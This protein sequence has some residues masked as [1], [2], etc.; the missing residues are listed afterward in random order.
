MNL[1]GAIGTIAGFLVVLAG[2][3]ALCLLA[4]W[5]INELP[6]DNKG[7]NILSIVTGTGGVVGT[8]VGAYFGVKLGSAGAKEAT[9][10]AVELAA[11]ADPATAQA[12]LQ[13][14]PSPSH[15]AAS[16]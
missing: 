15:P 7:Q 12:Y 13:Q 5:G 1:A 10:R 6:T 4:V 14:N 8:I 9:T 3:A 16:A 11:L 2:I